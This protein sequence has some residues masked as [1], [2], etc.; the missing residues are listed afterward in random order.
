MIEKNYF[1]EKKGTL[2]IGGRLLEWGECGDY[3]ICKHL[4][5]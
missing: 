3:R 4:T 5:R 2:I 1:K